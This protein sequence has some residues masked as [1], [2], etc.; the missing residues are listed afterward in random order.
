MSTFA[1]AFATCS[2]IASVAFA[3]GSRRERIRAE[4][5]EAEWAALLADRAEKARQ[6]ALAKAISDAQLVR[7]LAMRCYPTGDPDDVVELG[8]IHDM[9]AADGAGH[10]WFIHVRV[11]T[12]ISDRLAQAGIWETQFRPT[13][14]LLNF[15][16]PTILSGSAAAATSVSAG[17][18]DH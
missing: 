7:E 6:V 11:P 1:L 16:L 9:A 12:E 13:A 5:S 4:R 15:L 10:D 18:E 17:E 3:W 14:A 8:P 2:L